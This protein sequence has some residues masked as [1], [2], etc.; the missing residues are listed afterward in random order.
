MASAAS[1]Q[2]TQV[3][4]AEMSFKHPNYFSV[5]RFLIRCLNCP[6]LPSDHPP[7]LRAEPGAA[8]VREHGA[9]AAQP[10]AQPRPPRRHMVGTDHSEGDFGEQNFI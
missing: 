2:T 9:A 5:N 8:A 10:G 6:T 1:L 7:L 3:V 4:S